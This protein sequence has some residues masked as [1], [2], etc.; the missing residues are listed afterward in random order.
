VALLGGV[1][2]LF[3]PGE[4]YSYCNAGFVV[5][6][7]IIEVLDGRSWDES[8]RARLVEPLGLRSTV[9]LPEEAILHRAAVGHVADGTP[10]RTWQL[11]RS[12]G[13]AG[14]IT[15]SGGDVLRYARFHLDNFQAMREPQI[16]YPG[17]SDIVQIGLAWRLHDWSGHHLFGHDGGTISQLA[18]LRIHPEARVAMVLLTNSANGNALFEAVATEVFTQYADVAPPPAPEPISGEVTSDAILGT[19]EREGVHLE[20]ARAGDRLLMTYNATGPRLAFAEEPV[21]EYELHPT[22]PPDGNHYV[23]RSTPDQ[24]WAPVTFT[25]THLFTSGRLTPRS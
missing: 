7:R 8:L 4:S 22:N 20:V 11:P 25:P 1:D 9:T 12:I 3:A 5:L 21:V 10:V 18:Y 17:G 6:G 14:L 13:P 19:Y 15:A 24:P 23:T 2:H 16:D